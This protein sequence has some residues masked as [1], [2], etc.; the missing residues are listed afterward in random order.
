MENPLRADDARALPRFDAIAPEHVEPAMRALLAELERR[1][2]GAREERRADL[3]GRGRAARAD[4]RP[5]RYTVG[6]RRPP[7]GRAELAG[8]ARRARGGA[9]RRGALRLRVAPEQADLRRARRAREEPRA[10]RASTRA[11]RRIVDAPDP[12]RGARGRR[13]RGR[14]AGALPGDRDRARRAPDRVLEPRARR[15]Q[16]VRARAARPRRG[17]G[18]AARARSTWRRSPRAQ[19]AR[20]A[21]RRSAGPWRITLDQPSLVP[22]LQ[23]L[24]RRDLRE[25]LYRAY[26]TR[27]SAGDDDNTPL[28][29]T[30]PAP[31]P[32]GG[33]PAR[34]RDLRRAVARLEDGARRRRR[35][36]GCSRS[37]ARVSYA[38]AEREL[39]ELRAL[40]ARA[41]RDRASSRTGTSRSGP[42]ACARSATPTATR[43][44]ARTSRCPRVLDGPVRARR[45]P[46][47][48]ARSAPP[49]AR[50]RSGIPTCA[51]SAS[52]TTGGQPLAAF[53]LDPYR[54]P[55]RSAAARGWTS[56]SAAA[57]AR[58]PGGARACRSPTW[59][60]TRRRR[61]A[62]S[63]R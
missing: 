33:A 15:D 1:A 31:A 45:A 2:R 4:R 63:R 39:A 6:R 12:R 60:A 43:S 52:P 42:S 25:Q 11:Q 16:G 21:P 3:V 9:A 7:D 41:R 13:P 20:R 29:A 50:R 18:P 22:A 38:A 48:R 53:Y 26:V 51:S 56:A 46:V 28:I 14:G 44:C 5:A 57:A 17:R 8:A 61:S 49:T 36:G 19:R 55:P 58:R 34:L 27:A 54:G 23:H 59:S 35:C 24:R 30:H 10:S 62:T 32:R 37:C 40:R 47:R